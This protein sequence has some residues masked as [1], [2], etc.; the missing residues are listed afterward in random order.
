[1]FFYGLFSP[2]LSFFF[3]WWIDPTTTAS[4]LLSP[5]CRATYPVPFLPLSPIYQSSIPNFVCIPMLKSG[6]QVI[7]VV[8]YR[9]SCSAH[10]QSEQIAKILNFGVD[11]FWSWLSWT[12]LFIEVGWAGHSGFRSADMFTNEKSAGKKRQVKENK[13]N[14]KKQKKNRMNIFI[15]SDL[16]QKD[17][18]LCGF[19]MNLF[20]FLTRRRKR[21]FILDACIS[22]RVNN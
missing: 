22:L 17:L 19:F 4:F 21:F 20:R 5:L 8:P 16:R 6:I 14:K 10:D 2:L 9:L 11:S 3:F 1:M 13:T 15:S 12:H 7:F 18:I